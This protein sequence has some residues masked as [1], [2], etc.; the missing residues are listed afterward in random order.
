MSLA[1]PVVVDANVHLTA[2]S[3]YGEASGACGWPSDWQPGATL[4]ADSYAREMAA[5]GVTAAVAVTSIRV[6]GFDNAYALAAAGRDER[7]VAVGNV[8]VL[9]RR[10]PPTLAAWAERGLRG[11][12]FFGGAH[13]DAAD[14]L[15]DGRA[16]AAWRRAGELGLPVSAQRTRLNTLPALAAMAERLPDVAVVIHSMADP[17][18]RGGPDFADAQPL[19]AMARFPRVYLC[20]SM[21]NVAAAAGTGFFE[22]LVERFGPHRLMWGSYSLFGG[23]RSGVAAPT[24]AAIV[25]GVRDAFAFLPPADLDWLLGRT[26]WSLYGRGVP[27]WES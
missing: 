11:V 13:T 1:G 6:S 2:A 27:A 3:G 10:A 8:D 16:I 18:I 24:L 19:L 14:W 4:S 22:A 26:A 5:S 25:D 20:L 9:A 17:P 7:L 12:R 23:S 21:R 15:D